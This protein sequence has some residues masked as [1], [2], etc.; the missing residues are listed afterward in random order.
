VVRYSGMPLTF[1]P[2]G[3][4]RAKGAR[5]SLSNADLVHL[6]LALLLLLL[7]AHG[8]GLLFVRLRQ[9]KV[10]GEILGGLLLGPTLFGL[11]LPSW[12]RGV[13]QSGT[14]TP[15]ALGVFYQLGLVLLMYCSGAELRSILARR[16]RR[17]TVGIALLANAAP[18]VAGVA[19]LRFY[20]S[21]RFLGRA[22]DRTAFVLVFALAMAVTSIPVISRIMADLGILGTRFARIVLSVAVLEDL[23]VYVVLNFALAMVVP[24]HAERF[25]LPSM[26]ALH[27]SGAASDVY[28]V[29]VTLAFFALPALLGPGFVGRLAGRRGN[30]LHRASP[31]G[32][33][34]SV[35]LAMTG[36]A[37]FVGVSPIFGAMLAGILAGD[38]HGAAAEA[39]QTIQG[40][41][42]AFFIPVYFAVVGLRLDLAHH[43][44][45]LF[46]VFFLVFA[47]LTKTLSAYGGARLAGVD[48]TGARNLA[49]ALNARGGPGI[50]LASVAFDAGI[51]GL[52]FYTSLV[53][54][55]LV[56][57][58]LAGSWLEAALRRGPSLLAEDAVDPTTARTVPE[59][60]T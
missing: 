32:F 10:A 15:V 27:R 38:L 37:A 45:P 30:L 60:S 46:F 24:P 18:F 33:Q 21:E 7:A 47:C 39:R 14:A 53:M 29:V 54:L 16:E 13:F 31:I 9:P 49:V 17:A 26:L 40:F 8:L 19:F 48:K 34:L 25:S 12:Q 28:Y 20:D 41:A 52:S 55:A 51:I 23:L 11:L 2:S 43:F 58:V 22:H 57:S 5:L 35:L 1:P 59:S 3:Q 6:L 56:T 44:E 50:V 4:S 42:Y 36:L